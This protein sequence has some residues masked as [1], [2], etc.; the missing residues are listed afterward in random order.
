MQKYQKG[1]IACLDG[2]NVAKGQVAL[3]FKV[4]IFLKAL[5][6]LNKM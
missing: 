1:D 6:S 3:Q 4:N 2:R 5:K